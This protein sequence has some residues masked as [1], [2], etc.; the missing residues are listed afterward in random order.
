MPTIIMHDW[1]LLAVFVQATLSLH[2]CI[3]AVHVLCVLFPAFM[4]RRL[5]KARALAAADLYVSLFSIG[6]IISHVATTAAAA[7]T[8]PTP[9]ITAAVNTT[10]REQPSQPQLQLRQ[11]E[12]QQQ[13]LRRVLAYWVAAMSLTRLIAAVYTDS[14]GGTLVAA[15][16]MYLLEALSFEFEGTTTCTVPHR[17]ARIVSVVSLSLCIATLFLAVR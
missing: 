5:G 11:L 12:E 9:T 3:D 8:T 17:P 15:A 2:A 6:A 10:P 4:A 13:L 16:V 14:A 7:A 1:L